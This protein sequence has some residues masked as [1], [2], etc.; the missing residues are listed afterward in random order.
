[1]LPGAAVHDLRAPRAPLAAAAR[2][3]PPAAAQ[4]GALTRT[5]ALALT[6]TLTLTLTCEF[7]IES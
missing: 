7:K 1:M 4:P 5:L 6:P 2:Q 3:A